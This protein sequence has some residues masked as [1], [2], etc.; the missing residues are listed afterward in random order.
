[1]EVEGEDSDNLFTR[2]KEYSHYTDITD[3]TLILC[4]MQAFYLIRAFANITI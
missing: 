4:W 3:V 2:I 1:M